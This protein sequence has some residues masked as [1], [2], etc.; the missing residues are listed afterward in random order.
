LYSKIEHIGIA[1]RS[2]DDA[3]RVYAAGLG[4]KVEHVEEVADQRIRVA[5]LPI[6]ESRLELLEPMGEDSPVAKFIARRGE[7]MH[8][9][10]FQVEDIM[11][12]IGKLKA[13]GV[14]MIDETPRPGAAGCM[15]A[16]VHPCSTCGVLVELS[17]PA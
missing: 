3:L 10:C 1:V 9:I 16:F 8:H 6:G 12:E 2:L 17:Q 15:V 5:L 14:R 11:L 7:G 13:T 4:F